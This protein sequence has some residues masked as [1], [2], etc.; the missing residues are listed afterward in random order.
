MK[1]IGLAGELG[2]YILD[3]VKVYD[4][5]QKSEEARKTIESIIDSV[6][7]RLQTEYSVIFEEVA[8]DFGGIV[9]SIAAGNLIPQGVIISATG[10]MFDLA[11][12]LYDT[13]NFIGVRI[14]FNARSSGRF[15]YY[16]TGKY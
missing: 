5:I 6:R 1:R 11:D 12:N 15:D 7:E 13:L 16:M 8:K 10:I 14:D 2:F 9:F 4:S 3:G